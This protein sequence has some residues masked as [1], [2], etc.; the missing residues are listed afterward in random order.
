MIDDGAGVLAHVVDDPAAT[1]PTVSLNSGRS[2]PQL[3]FGVFRVPPEDTERLVSEALEAG[4]RHIDTAAIYRNEVGVGRAIAA[5]GIPRDELFVTTKLFNDA[6]GEQRAPAA[7]EGSLDALGMDYVDLYLIHWP[8]PQFDLYVE[9]WRVLEQ[10]AADGRARSIGV[11]N[12][13]PHHLERLLAR[14]DVVPAVNQIEMHPILQQQAA[15]EFC[16]AHGIAVEAWSPLGAGQLPLFGLPPIA[17]IA[18]EVG[19]TPAQV[20]L[21]WHVQRDTIVIPKSSAPERM[22][23][24]A[25]IFDFSLTAEQ[26]A[27]I[28]ALERGGRTGFHPDEWH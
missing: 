15:A 4:Y 21:R 10:F 28:T 2:I 20:V 3:G 7:F 13:L 19:R 1:V 22:R 5:S 14:A 18:E 6:Q 27:A 12:F 9:T 26:M 17:R 25:R 8:A 16:H 11:S 23:E 24:N